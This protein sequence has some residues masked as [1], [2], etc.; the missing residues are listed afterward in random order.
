MA[1]PQKNARVLEALDASSRFAKNDLNDLRLGDVLQLNETAFTLDEL[2]SRLTTLRAQ[3]FT[4][5]GYPDDDGIHANGGRPGAKLGPARIR[6]FFSRLTPPAFIANRDNPAIFDLGNVPIA[7]DLATRHQVAR[8]VADQVHRQNIRPIS[9]GGGHDY[10]FPDAAA[11]CQ[12]VLARGERPLVINFDAHLDVRPMN[13]GITSGTP[14]FRLLE[15]FPDIDFVEV[16]LQSQ[17]NSHTH[18][19]WLKSRGGRYSFE[20]E[21][22]QTKESLTRV[23]QR[24]TSNFNVAG[25]RPLFLSVDI[26]AF[27]SAI[28]PGASQSWPT[29]FQA[30]DFFDC[31]SWCLKTFDVRGLGIYEVSPPLDVDDR[32]ARLAALIAHRFV[33][34]L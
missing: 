17:C 12:S 21:R 24:E 27:S 9:F 4:L 1:S 34:Q 3:S 22:H 25:R 29:G 8:S 15:E 23:L 19:E 33:F 26:D 5:V 11:F 32:T 7:D 28:A 31:F 20:E 6:H 13:H 18:L 2:K 14:F 16:G 30:T 10:G